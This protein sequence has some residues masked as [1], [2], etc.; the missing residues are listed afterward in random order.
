[1]TA[2]SER[3]R[4]IWAQVA[5]TAGFLV[6]GAVVIGRAMTKAHQTAQLQAEFVSTVSHE[7][8]SPLTAIRQLSEMLALGR[9][10]PDNRRQ[11][12]YEAL[13]GETDRLQRLVERLLQFGRLEAGAASQVRLRVDVRSVVEEVKSEFAEA[14]AERACGMVVNTTPPSLAVSGDPEGLRLALRNLVDNALK[15]SPPDSPVEIEW[16]RTGQGVAIS[17]RDQGIGIPA[18]EHQSIFRKFVRGRAA[19]E[20]RIQGTG[21]GLAMVQQIVTSHGGR[22]EVDSEFG[23]GSTFS[24]ILPPAHES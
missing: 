11:R 14:L 12:Y 13:L 15:Y 24:M 4:F 21:L 1:M 2:L 20:G 16:S 23:R 18:Q 9:V 19:I 7:F 5:L 6:T 3:R 22:V 17:V 8:R 10:P